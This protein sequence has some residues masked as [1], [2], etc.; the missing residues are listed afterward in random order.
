[1]AIETPK[2]VAPQLPPILWLLRALVVA[3]VCSG[4]L[5]IGTIAFLA[6]DGT[7]PATIVTSTE[8]ELIAITLVFLALLSIYNARAFA[9]EADRI[10]ETE[11]R[12]L[13]KLRTAFRD[14]TTRLLDRNAAHWKEQTDRLVDA[15]STLKKVVE[16]QS[17]ALDLTSAGIRLNEQ[18]LQLEQERE[19]LRVE[20]QLLQRRRLQPLL[21]LSLETPVTLIKHMNVF[22]HNRGMDGRNLVL[23][24][25]IQPGQVHQHL[26]QGIAPQ[27]VAK[28][29]FGDISTCDVLPSRLYTCGWGLGRG[30]RPR[31]VGRSVHVLCS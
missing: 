15:T 16:L 3:A 10:V 28:V 29:D 2:S 30:A 27:E 26:A 5:V 4:A 8:T 13:E 12:E 6:H 21:G 7:S 19:R 25:G 23:Y 18:L 11:Q 17:G 9:G 22:I 14:E 20:E 24:F 31:V 1:M